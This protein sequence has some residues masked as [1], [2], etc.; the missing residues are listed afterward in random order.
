M[1][2]RPRRRGS[3]G[4]LCRAIFRRTGSRRA[5]WSQYFPFVTVAKLAPAPAGYFGAEDPYGILPNMP[6]ALLAP[7][8]LFLLGRRARG[9]APGL[10]CFCAVAALTAVAMAFPLIFFQAA[11]NR[12]MVD[13]T[14]AVILLACL[15]ALALSGRPW[16]RGSTAALGTL[17]IC[18]VGA[19][20]AVFGLLASFRHNE[21]FRDEHPALYRRVAY[22]WNWLSYE[23]DRL[24][25]N[26]WTAGNGRDLP[27]GPQRDG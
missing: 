15:G 19:Y 4:V 10:R 7:G 18:G 16:F 22:R 5:G 9:G 3:P 17:A 26:M 21:L 8:A 6:F 1:T 12:Y 27:G 2:T 11:L 13:F 24:G 23:Y 25:Q 20:S 14:P